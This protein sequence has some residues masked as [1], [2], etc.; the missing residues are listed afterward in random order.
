MGKKTYRVFRREFLNNEG[1]YAGAYIIAKVEDT[2]G[3]RQTEDKEVRPSASLE[4]AD[5]SKSIYL[6]IDVGGEWGTNTVHKLDKLIEVLE[7]TR[8]A[9]IEENEL[10]DRRRE[11]RREKGWG[12]NSDDPLERLTR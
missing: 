9:V 6:E 2:S 10:S 1:F 3:K 12:D 8:E 7:E 11:E 4:I 5:C